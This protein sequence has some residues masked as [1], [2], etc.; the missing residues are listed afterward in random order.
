MALATA[1][2][3][4]GLVLLL[5]EILLPGA[6]LG[7]CAILSLIASVVVAYMTTDY[8]THF[9]IVTLVTAFCFIVGFVKWFPRSF[10]AKQFVSTSTSGDIGID[11]SELVNQTGPAY[12]DLHPSGKA[13]IGDQLVHV[14]TEGTFIDKDTPIRVVAVE[15]TRVVVR[16]K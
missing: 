1:L 13:F 2:L 4:L 6:V 16:K 15:G 5:L 10:I 8:G 9:L 7:T 11:L 12:T 14:V 3:V